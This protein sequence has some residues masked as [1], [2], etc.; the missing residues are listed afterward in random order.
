VPYTV[1]LYSN[2]PFFTQASYGEI[3]IKQPNGSV[4]ITSNYL[5]AGSDLEIVN[6]GTD[7]NCSSNT[8]FTVSYTWQNVADTY[9]PGNE[10][11]CALNLFNDCAVTN[12]N[13][14]IGFTHG[15]TYNSA[16][17]F[18]HPCDRTDQAYI[19]TGTGINSCTNVVGA[20]NLCTPPSGFTGTDY[21]Q[22][23]YRAVTSGSSNL[24]DDQTSDPK[25][26]KITGSGTPGTD[27]VLMD[28]C[29]DVIDLRDMVPSSGTWLVRYRNRHITGCSVAGS[30][31]GNW[32]SNYITEVFN[33]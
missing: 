33:L 4:L 6:D 22:V 32:G 26:G 23:E 11:E 25:Y 15:V 18:T 7:P 21:H 8:L 17:V 20:Y 16:D 12:Y 13:N 31:G 10:V 14:T 19:T 29:C 2:N 9:F 3:R 5:I 27:A 24:W 30:L 1:L 28:A